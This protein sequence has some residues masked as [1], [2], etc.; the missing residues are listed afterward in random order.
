MGGKDDELLKTKERLLKENITIEEEKKELLK[1]LEKE[2][3]N[4]SIY[5]DKQ[6]KA[7]AAITDY[8]NQLT[9]AQ[10][11]LAQ[12]EAARQDAMAEKKVLEQEVVSIKKD[13]DDVNMA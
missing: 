5:H 8:E 13:I 11:T 3:G 4:L 9:V 12:R 10:E 2:Q 7:S 1:T 6:A